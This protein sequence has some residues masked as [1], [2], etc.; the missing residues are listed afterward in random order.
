MPT[1]IIFPQKWTENKKTFEMNLIWRDVVGEA[2]FW[3]S[4]KIF[5]INLKSRFC[6]LLWQIFIKVGTI[7][8]SHNLSVKSFKTL[9]CQ[10]FQ[11]LPL[12]TNYFYHL[13]IWHSSTFTN[14]KWNNWL[15]KMSF[16]NEAV[17]EKATEDL[18]SHVLKIFEFY[19][20]SFNSN[21]MFLFRLK[22]CQ[23]IKR[24]YNLKNFCR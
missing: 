11:F 18:S 7:W 24:N 14:K 16:G 4:L 20:S 8:R 6:L 12:R 23:V 13:I 17:T 10:D 5:Q 19:I 3:I 21:W 22:Y 9:L 2:W 15:T 1:G